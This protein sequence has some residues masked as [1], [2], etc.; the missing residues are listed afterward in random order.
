M[1]VKG[2]LS[3]V[4]C[5]LACLLASFLPSFLPSTTWIPGHLSVWQ[6]ALPLKVSHSLCLKDF[7]HLNEA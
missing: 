3:E 1:E 5:L 7:E 2:Q 4:A 6:M